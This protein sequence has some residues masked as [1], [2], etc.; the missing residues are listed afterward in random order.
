[1]RLLEGG[2]LDEL[3]EPGPNVEIV[4]NLEKEWVVIDL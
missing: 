3:T 4:H 1:M 2:I